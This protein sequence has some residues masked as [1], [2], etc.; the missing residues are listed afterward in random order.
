MKNA[1]SQKN[2]DKFNRMHDT[3]SS[4]MMD[5]DVINNKTSNMVL[6]SEF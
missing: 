4:M 6:Q 2:L 3:L 1:W 5:F